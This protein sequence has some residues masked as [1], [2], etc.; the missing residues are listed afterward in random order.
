MQKLVQR[1]RRYLI[2]GLIVIAPIGVTVFVLSWLFQTLDPIIG[3]YLPQISG[4]EPR[5]LGLVALLVLLVVVGWASQKALGRRA[6]RVW[7]GF[8]NRVPVA[9]RLYSASSHV[10][11]AVLTRDQK[12]FRHCALIEYPS[13]GSHTLVFETADAA[14]EAEDV[15]GEPAVAVFLPT[16]PNPASGFLLFVPRSRVH[17]LDMSV[18]EGFKMIFSAGMAVPEVAGAEGAVNES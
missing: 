14:D 12:L 7:N 5:G 11:E 1:L 17:R 15:I 16:V 6:L 13:P 4:Y 18:E 9:R 10:F 2:T 3:R 8:A